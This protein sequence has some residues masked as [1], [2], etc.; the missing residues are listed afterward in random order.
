LFETVKGQ[1]IAIRM[2][3][4]EIKEKTLPQT[5]LFH[6]PDG[7]GKFLTAV[8]VARTVNCEGTLSSFCTCPSCIRIYR[9]AS[10]NLY[11]ISRS[12]L[13]NT[14]ELWKHYGVKEENREWFIYDLKRFLISISEEEKYKREY[15]LINEV[16]NSHEKL[17]NYRDILKNIIKA[18]DSQKSRNISID[19]IRNLQHYLGVR[20]GSGKCKV[21]IIDGAENMNEEAQ[22]SFL[23]VSEETPGNS[24][25]ILT[26]V[27]R[28]SIKETIRS[29]A[30]NYRFV[31][32]NNKTRREIA[33]MKFG[34]DDDMRLPV[35]SYEPDR[36]RDYFQ[37]LRAGK[38]SM[39]EVLQ[40]VEEIVDSDQII[41]FLDYT[42]DIFKKEVQNMGKESIE[43][44]Y[45]LE[46]L[47]KKT[48]STKNAILNRN[49]NPEIALSDFTLN[50]IISIL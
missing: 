49:A 18:Y 25:I 16:V 24:I 30:R 45:E 19:T 35:L 4:N 10:I 6:G 33:L 50:Y 38:E 36:M 29:R 11:I 12:N 13:R 26:T 47:M 20:S 22:N 2:L 17:Q 37:K 1:K 27:N 9:F 48:I 8:E 41:G 3:I 7:C 31:H 21:V 14:F 5:L 32:L 34:Q 15:E 23:K 28:D 40:V 42:M 39:E 46:G 44:I 43:K